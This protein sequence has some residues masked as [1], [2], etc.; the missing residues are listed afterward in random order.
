MPDRA[1]VVRNHPDD[2]RLTLTFISEFIQQGAT[3]EPVVAAARQAV[4]DQLARYP[5]SDSTSRQLAMMEGVWSWVK[6]HIAFVHDPHNGAM[7]FELV[8]D[9]ENI[10]RNRAGDCDEHVIL[11]GA[12]LRAV[13]FGQGQLAIVVGGPYSPDIKQYEP[14]HVVLIARCSEGARLSLKDAL[15]SGLAC[16]V[17]T[18]IDQPFNTLAGAGEWQ[19]WEWE[20]RR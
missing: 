16:V 7:Q 5:T 4:A 12:M 20:R 17:D 1:P 18:T 10:L 15:A 8:S 19:Y 3:F 6:Q 9:C 2:V 14:V 13:G 11:C